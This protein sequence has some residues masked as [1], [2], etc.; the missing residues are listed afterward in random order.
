MSIYFL[1]GM[2]KVLDSFFEHQPDLLCLLTARGLLY[3]CVFVTSSFL[4]VASTYRKYASVTSLLNFPLV[5]IYTFLEDALDL[6]DSGQVGG[7]LGNNSALS[8]PQAPG[9]TL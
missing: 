4:H 6:P 9:P 3:E 5:S 2:P 8:S 1:S 7:S